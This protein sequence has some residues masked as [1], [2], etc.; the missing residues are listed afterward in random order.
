MEPPDG[1]VSPREPTL[2]AYL[3]LRQAIF[4][5]RVP[6]TFGA[7]ALTG[8]CLCPSHQQSIV[9]CRRLSWQLSRG[10]QRLGVAR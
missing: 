3:I 2:V 8:S 1:G 4:Q 6:W 7:K 9:G 10:L 5:T